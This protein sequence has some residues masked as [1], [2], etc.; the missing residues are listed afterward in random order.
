MITRSSAEVPSQWLSFRMDGEEYGIDVLQVQEIH[1]YQSPTPLFNAPAYVNGVLELRGEVV[2]VIDLRSKLGLRRK[3]YDAATVTIMLRL[4]RGL[5][6][7]VVEGVS[8]V[9]TLL[10]QQLRAMPLAGDG[11]DPGYLLAMGVQDE[12]ALILVDAQKLVDGDGLQTGLP[13]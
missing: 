6:G 12:R 11:A 8:D 2:P 5:V 3:D 1:C 9:V 13:A 4:A 10:P 7:M